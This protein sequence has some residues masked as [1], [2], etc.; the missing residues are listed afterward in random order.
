MTMSMGAD[1]NHML[2]PAGRRLHLCCAL[3]TRQEGREPA[4]H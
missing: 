2:D 4:P 3:H 1:K